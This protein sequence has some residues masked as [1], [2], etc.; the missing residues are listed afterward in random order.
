M[1]KSKSFS[2]KINYLEEVAVDVLENKSCT[3]GLK[4][5]LRALI[6]EITL[7]RNHITNLDK[8]EE[9]LN[10]L[11]KK[12]IQIG[13]GTHLINGY[14]NIDIMPPAD[15]L[16]DV[17][18]GLPLENNVGEIIFSE[19][20]L[21]HIDYPVSVEKFVKECFR[22]LKSDGKLILGVPDSS[23]MIDS[24]VKRDKAFFNKIMN[25]WYSKRNHH[26]RVDTYIDLLNYHFRDQDDDK[27]YSPHFWSYDYEKL[28]ALLTKNG[29][30]K[31]TKWKFNRKIASLKRNFGS[32]YVI[33]IK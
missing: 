26:F 32:I 30:K 28:R 4:R 21:E 7:C 8:L 11:D 16:Y 1:S 18:E 22:V 20:F 2:G 24:Y 19:H 29:F 10:E 25:G 23:L 33:A 5:S 9:N 12:N 3:H 6:K 15:I 13:S 31:I 17:R 14:L 27:K